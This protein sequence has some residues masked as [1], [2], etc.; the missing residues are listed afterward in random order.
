LSVL[1]FPLDIVC[2]GS[3]ID[4]SASGALESVIIG[5]LSVIS[6]TAFVVVLEFSSKFWFVSLTAFVVGSKGSDAS[7]WEACYF[8]FSSSPNCF[9]SNF[10][11][12]NFLKVLAL[13]HYWFWTT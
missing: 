1:A 11:S 5:K 10:D 6:S 4:L 2:C 7:Y 13:S 12:A 9:I 3:V 8:R